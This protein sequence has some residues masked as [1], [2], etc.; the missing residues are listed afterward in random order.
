MN[1]INIT[2]QDLTG[3]FSR[4]FSSQANFT[5][6]ADLITAERALSVLAPEALDL[7]TTDVLEQIHRRL[8]DYT[9]EEASRALNDIADLMGAGSQAR[10]PHS[11]VF[12]VSNLLEDSQYLRDACRQFA[13]DGIP[14]RDLAKAIRAL[15]MPG[16]K[17][18]LTDEHND[19]ENAAHA[20][21]RN[22]PTPW[23][24]ELDCVAG[25]G[26]LIGT[27]NEEGDFNHFIQVNISN[28]SLDQDDDA[29]L[30]EY[31]KHARPAN[32]AA[33]FGLIRAQAKE[34]A[35]LRKERRASQ[36]NEM[37]DFAFWVTLQDSLN[38]L[39]PIEVLRGVAFSPES[40]EPCQHRMLA[41]PEAVRFEKV[42]KLAQMHNAERADNAAHRAETAKAAA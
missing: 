39:S 15:K 7:I 40:L 25:E 4:F 27:R 31:L 34:I 6:R 9:R 29:T 14:P 42:M 2:T 13:A 12:C 8:H 26:A 35:E 38:E 16:E 33:M 41:Y 24:W 10:T 22:Y 3:W 21:A 30:A 32:I 19:L 20:I 17:G 36:L 5:Q 23:D 1:D 28:C 18:E 11:I 37:P